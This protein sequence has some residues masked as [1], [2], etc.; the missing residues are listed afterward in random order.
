M[1]LCCTLYLYCNMRI[2]LLFGSDISCFKTTTNIVHGGWYNKMFKN[3]LLFGS[4]SPCIKIMRNTAFGLKL[5][6]NLL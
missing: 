5:Y 3:V 4:G 6:H 1:A 2:L